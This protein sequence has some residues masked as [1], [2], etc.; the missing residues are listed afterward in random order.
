M[1]SEKRIDKNPK[2]TIRAEWLLRIDELGHRIENH[3]EE[4]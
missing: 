3:E 2:C 4:D 1:I